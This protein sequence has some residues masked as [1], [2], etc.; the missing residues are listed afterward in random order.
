M[1][2]EEIE[3][4]VLQI[5]PREQALLGDPTG[6]IYGSPQ[7]E[8]TGVAVT[9]TPNL[10]VLHQ[11]TAQKL[12]FILTHEL[13][14]IPEADSEWFAT[15]G[16]EAQAPANVARRALLDRYGMVIC[17][18]HS[19]WDCAPGEGVA[20]S[21]ARV[22]GLTEVVHTSRFVRVYEITPVTL[23]E[24][25][26]HIKRRLGVPQVRVGGDLA[27]V[28]S[29][30]GLGYGGLAQ[31]FNFVDEFAMNGADVVIAGEAVDYAIRG[32]L[33]ANIA[34][35]ETSHIGSENPGMRNFARLLRE[36]LPEAIPVEFL[37]A[38]YEWTFL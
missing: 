32:A 4:I 11:A 18:C 5:A 30:V 2:A 8:V 6:L 20:D 35:I 31:A 12:N 21:L 23:A 7:I 25:A 33:D 13:P 38:A 14:F 27:R 19:N 1:T 36:R 3:Q 26:T 24:L 10:R 34:F 28:V 22:L 15:Y 16:D 9:W 17:R 37:D 29:R